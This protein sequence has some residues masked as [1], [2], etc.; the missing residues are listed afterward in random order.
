M[1]ASAAGIR[2][3][4]A[5]VE[6]AVTGLQKA[7]RDLAAFGTSLKGV[8][9][10]FAGIGVGL[11]TPFVLA[12]KQLESFE[13]KMA[14]VRAITNAS[15]ADF[16][17]LGDKA[18][19]LGL[20]TVF[21]ASDAAEAMGNFAQAGFSVNE[22][23]LAVG[24]TLDLAAAAQLDVATSA[25]IASKIMR[26]MGISAGNLSGVVDVLAKAATTSNTN[27]EQLGDAFK[28]V[29]PV[30]RTAGIGLEEITAAIQLLSNAGIQGEM[31]GTTLRGMILSLASP[32]EE[33]KKTLKGLG[34]QTQDSQGNFRS[35]VDIIGQFDRA[36]AGVGTGKRLEVLGKV[37]SDR[38]AAGA[39]E[40]I[41]QGP[42]KLGEATS[43][44]GGSS[45]TASRIAKTQLDTLH[46]AIK[47]FESSVEGLAIVVAEALLPTLREWGAQLVDLTNTIALLAKNNKGFVLGVAKAAL[48]IAGFG[49][50]LLAAGF[51]VRALSFTFGAI[52]ATIKTVAAVIG[53]VNAAFRLLAITINL[54][55]A[56]T[57]A[58]GVLSTV[59]GAILSPVGLLTVGLI[60]LS[61]WLV[62]TGKSGEVLGWLGQRFAELQSDATAA[63]GGIA[64]ALKAG[65]IQ[66][67]AEILWGTLKLEWLKGTNF[68]SAAW[69]E[70]SNAFVDVAEGAGLAAWGAMVDLWANIQ[71]LWATA[72]S[73]LSGSWGSLI[74]MIVK[75][76][77]GLAPILARVFGID[78]KGLIDK[79][80]GAVGSEADRK[81]ALGGQ[82]A[83]IEADRQ[84]KQQGLAG[85]GQAGAE[86]RRR[87]AAGSI[88][89]G[90]AAQKTAEGELAAAIAAAKAKAAKVAEPAGAA[91]P[92]GPLAQA[93][94][95]RS[96]DQ[97]EGK[98]SATGTFSATAV[99]GLGRGGGN[100]QVDEQKI[101]NQ[102][103]RSV[104]GRLR[105]GGFVADA[106]KA[107]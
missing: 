85:Q 76:L 82:L 32:S 23:M 81:R 74:E 93:S 16:A 66:L 4:R 54:A 78:I 14:R 67:A 34:I 30:A 11:T 43:K 94:V 100:P 5:Y 10:S 48:A 3:G 64:D 60:A 105:R 98:V 68:L 57:A 59:I 53:V 86:A 88:G 18:K 63:F 107:S 83:A 70:W 55:S 6:M 35:L 73:N 39:A 75:S 46:G 92:G 56:A 26:G 41:S 71:K 79:A 36:L 77:G 19:Q 8:G 21:S 90:L 80:T 103:L 31:A 91:G 44:L 24:P 52:A 28:F 102:L 2:A 13:S 62:K 40:L 69:S 72:I 51:A 27:I 12:S 61:V 7:E 33:A 45:G 42:G 25:D 9:K 22:I 38:Q 87:A 49:A 50:G 96:L 89:E 99:A 1:G 101:T 20:D 65:D 106:A 84:A 15:D 95:G 47:L 37:F 58:F 104:D 29:G 97:A 17:K